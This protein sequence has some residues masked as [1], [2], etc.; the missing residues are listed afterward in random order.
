MDDAALEAAARAECTAWGI[1]PDH[2]CGG[3]GCYIPLGETWPAWRVRL[4]M[5]R[6]AIDAHRAQI[7]AEIV[8]WLRE[9][10]DDHGDALFSESTTLQHA[11]YMIERGEHRREKA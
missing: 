2:Q 7:E 9:T 4:P 1:D 11:A 8:A 3:L 6:A 10:A 5:L